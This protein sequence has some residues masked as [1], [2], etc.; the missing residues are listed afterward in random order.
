MW[1]AGLISGP[2]IAQQPSQGLLPLNGGAVDLRL[3]TGP[4]RPQN[5][6]CFC[7]RQAVVVNRCKRCHTHR[8]KKITPPHRGAG[9]GLLA[10]V[11]QLLQR[12]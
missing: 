5:V 1:K 12:A 2:D 10:G 11:D 6:G 4:R 3:L 7:R 8:F 9:S